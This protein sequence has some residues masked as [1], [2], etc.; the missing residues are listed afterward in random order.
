MAVS[1]TGRGAKRFHIPE[2]LSHLFHRLLWQSAEVCGPLLRK[3][4]FKGIK[5][6]IQDYEENKL[7]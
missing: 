5:Q 2:A 1:F 4:V 3:N 6:D 7:Y